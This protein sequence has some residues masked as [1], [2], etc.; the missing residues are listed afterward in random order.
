MTSLSPAFASIPSA[1]A[2]PD[3]APAASTI[4]TFGV[5]FVVA[6]FDDSDPGSERMV[7]GVCFESSF[8]MLAAK[9]HNHALSVGTLPPSTNNSVT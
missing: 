2:R 6:R 1:S 9:A 5:G 3:S 7:A 4:K 8:K